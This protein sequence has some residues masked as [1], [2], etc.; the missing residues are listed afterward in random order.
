MRAITILTGALCAATLCAPALAADPKTTAD[1]LQK[2]E[3]AKV[4]LVYGRPD[5]R[6]NKYKSVQ[7]LPLAIP[8]ELRVVPSAD[9]LWPWND[10]PRRVDDRD[11]AALQQFYADTFRAELTKEGFAV[12]DAPRA[13]TLVIACELTDIISNPPGAAGLKPSG[14]VAIKMT[15][16]DG[17][18]RTLIATMSDRRFAHY[19]Y[20]ENTRATDLEQIRAAFQNWTHVIA[21]DIRDRAQKP[22]VDLWSCL[23][24]RKACPPNLPQ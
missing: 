1:G 21:Q 4:M 8:P 3:G 16:S 6:W 22:E 14:S 5:T 12:V 13:D 18:T 9:S 11:A 20:A 2:I 15:L 10:E 23:N 19:L 7:V 24:D 17:A